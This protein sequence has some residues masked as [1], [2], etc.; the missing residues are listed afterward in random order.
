ML[1]CVGAKDWALR[2]VVCF[3]PFA[4]RLYFPETIFACRVMCPVR[5]LMPVHIPIWTAATLLEDADLLGIARH[6]VPSA[7]CTC[8]CRAFV[9]HVF[10]TRCAR[11]P[12]PFGVLTCVPTIV[13]FG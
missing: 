4:F 2:T 11:A 1:R 12:R 13:A 7:L 8:T 9:R 5:S 6:G 10:R 3:N